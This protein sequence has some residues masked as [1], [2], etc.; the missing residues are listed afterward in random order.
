MLY[1]IALA[2]VCSL[3][4]AAYARRGITHPNAIFFLA[5]FVYIPLK[6]FFV[7][8]FD[9]SYAVPADDVGSLRS[10]DAVEYAGLLLLAYLLGAVVVHASCRLARLPAPVLEAE[11][12]FRL[13][14][15]TILIVLGI[16][17]AFSWLYGSEKIGDGLL[18]RSFTQERGM[19]YVSIVLDLLAVI[20]VWQLIEARKVIPAAL[21]FLFHAGYGIL[22]GRTAV[23][24]SLILAILI[25]L[26]MVK[27]K[28]PYAWMTV[29]PVVV[30]PLA[31]IHGI[32][33][34]RGGFDTGWAYVEEIL[35]SNE[36]FEILAMNL[37]NRIDQLEEFAVLAQGIAHGTVSVD[38]LWPFYVLVQFV[39]RG[40]WPDKPYLF[41]SEMMSIFYPAVLQEG[42]TFNFLG[43]GEMLYAFDLPGILIASCLTGYLLYLT[44]ANHD[45]S[46]HRPSVCVFYYAVPYTYLALGFQVGWMNT[47][48]PAFVVINLLVLF[49]VA[50]IRRVPVQGGA[51]NG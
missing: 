38:P 37:V 39:P 13:P 44:D 24:V 27:R 10:G 49:A 48:A 40:I 42:V 4:F 11:V 36:A 18:L 8:E 32:I 23:L 22:A 33:R 9:L 25:Y 50:R 43:V 20:A 46:K 26:N 5:F 34:V 47:V 6:Y 2:V 31:L 28:V 3:Y 1:F 12:R 15:A 14:L 30:V 16:L 7:R 35:F 41:N 19:G 21:L 45:R 17:V 51:A 29:G